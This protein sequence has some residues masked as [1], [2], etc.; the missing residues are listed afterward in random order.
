MKYV[1]LKVHIVVHFEPNLVRCAFIKCSTKVTGT[2]CIK[3]TDSGYK[4]Y[5]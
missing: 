1:L 5:M 3:K 2:T 4:K